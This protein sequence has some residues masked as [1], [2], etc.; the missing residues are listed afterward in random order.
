MRKGDLCHIPQGTVLL[1]LEA[2]KW[3]RPEKPIT[4]ILLREYN[5]DYILHIAGKV[6]CARK[7][8]VYPIKESSNGKINTN[9]TLER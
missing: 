4:G 5:H 2:T 8:D 1:N 7:K 9:S 6:W 3:F